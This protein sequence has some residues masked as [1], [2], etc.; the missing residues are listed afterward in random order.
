MRYMTFRA[1]IFTVIFLGALASSRDLKAESSNQAQTIVTIETKE[2]R[3]PVVNAEDVMLYQQRTRVPV[4]SVTPI[5]GQPVELYVAIDE[6][7][8]TDL[9]TQIQDLRKFVTSQPKNI[10]VGVAYLREGRAQILQKPTSDHGVAANVLRLPTAQVG[11][12]PFESITDLLKNWPEGEARREILLISSGIEPFGGTEL[13]NPYVDAAIA[14]AQRELVPVFVIYA[15]AAGHWGHTLWRTTWGQTY[16]SRIADETGAEGYNLNGLK[17]V[18]Y[19]PFLADVTQRIQRQ[20]LV[21][22]TPKPESK[23]GLVP[24]YAK[25]ELP[26]V[27][28]VTP[29]RAWVKGED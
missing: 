15:P 6:S 24:I 16:L 29:D 17:V 26:H 10:A 18:S 21:T 11:S 1:V 3:V 13:S 28:L 12:S 25:T 5:A 22:F 19:F 14:A 23:S 7:T 20:L 2:S 9:G 27:E 8:G 4:T